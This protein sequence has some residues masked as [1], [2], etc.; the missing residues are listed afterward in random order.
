VFEAP[1]SVGEATEHVDSW[2]ARPMVDVLHPGERHWAIL[3]ERLRET[4]A[5]ANLVP[6]AHLAAL[7]LEYG[8]TLCSTDADF[9]RFGRL[10][11]INPL[12]P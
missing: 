2:L 11:W 3:A 1:M 8:A 4:R 9:S 12:R 10:H 6:D 5:A 7:A